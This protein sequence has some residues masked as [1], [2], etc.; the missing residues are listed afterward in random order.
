MNEP[1]SRPL[2]SLLPTQLAHCISH[3]MRVYVITSIITSFRKKHVLH[4]HWNNGSFSQ[5]ENAGIRTWVTLSASFVYQH[6]FIGILCESE[7]NELPVQSTLPRRLSSSMVIIAIVVQQN[8]VENIHLVAMSTYMNLELKKTGNV[9][10]L[11]LRTC[12]T[13]WKKRGIGRWK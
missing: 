4:L 1:V 2:F 8:P 10:I 9:Q 3:W 5:H 6:T 7:N 12:I 11:N 13:S